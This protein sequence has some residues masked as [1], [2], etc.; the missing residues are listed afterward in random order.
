MSNESVYE[1]CGMGA[2]VGGVK[3]GMVERVR[4][5]TL[6]WFGHAERMKCDEFVKRC[7]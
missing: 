4:R 5:N 7:L 2:R 3:C 6:R 1:R